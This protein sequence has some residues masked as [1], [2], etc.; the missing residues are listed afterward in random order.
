MRAQVD[1]A[2]TSWCANL[3][4]LGFL[5]ERHINHAFLSALR[6]V[7]RRAE[8]DGLV[9]VITVDSKRAVPDG[10]TRLVWRRLTGRYGHDRQVI[11]D[12]FNE[13]AGPWDLWHNRMEHLARYV[14]H[15]GGRN[16]FWVEGPYAAGS[17]GEVPRRHLTGVGP[18]AYSEHRPPWP[19]TLSSWKHSFGFLARRYPVVEGEWANYSRANAAWACWDDA[20]RAVPRFLRYLARH[21]LGLVGYDLAGPRLLESASLADP[22]RIRADWTCSRSVNEGAGQLIMSWLHSHNG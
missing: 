20:P 17:L 19:H 10:R 13:P 14:R 11:F 21:K 5:Q 3:V 22:N 6:S 9:V 18:V 4:R 2:A 8:N 16:L 1:A 12:L 7:V 15:H